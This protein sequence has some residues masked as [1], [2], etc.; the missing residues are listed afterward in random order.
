MD[1]FQS[2][3]E[4][5]L[6]IAMVYNCSDFNESVFYPIYVAVLLLDVIQLIV[7]HLEVSS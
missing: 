4:V 6:S 2:A 7:I 1:D 3:E 5:S